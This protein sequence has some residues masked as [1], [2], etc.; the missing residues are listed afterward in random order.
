MAWIQLFPTSN[1]R[2]SQSVDRI[3]AN[4]LYIQT[5]TKV[6][7]YFDDAAPGNDGHHKFIH[8]P[9]QTA[10]ADPVVLLTGVVYQKHNAAGKDRLY[11]R[12][13]V[14]GGLPAPLN[15]IEQ[16]PTAITGQKVLA[17]SAGVKTVLDFTGYPNFQGVFTAYKSGNPGDRC[18]ASIFYNGTEVKVLPNG[19]DSLVHGAITQVDHDGKKLQIKKTAVAMTLNY[20]I[21]KTER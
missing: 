4:W 1:T 8:L 9:T 19:V 5:T 18:T 21:I 20:S 3:Q 6:D 2:I 15:R 17:A 14:I 13:P 7:H 16:I 11:Y 10:P 12:T